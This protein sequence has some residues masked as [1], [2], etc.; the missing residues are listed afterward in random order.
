VGEEKKTEAPVPVNVI[1]KS[2]IQYSQEDL[3]KLQLSV[4]VALNVKKATADLMK[5]AE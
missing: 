2:L 5:L 3:E 1:I 4:S